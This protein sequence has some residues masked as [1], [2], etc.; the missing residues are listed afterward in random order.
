[1]SSTYRSEYSLPSVPT[2]TGSRRGRSVYGGAGGR[3]VQVS[4]PSSGITAGFDPADSAAR[5]AVADNKKL[6]MKN[7]NDRLASYLAKVRSLETSNA[8]L[9][10]QIREW[11]DKQPPVLRDFSKYDAVIEDLRRNIRD[12][13]QDNASL[14]LQIDNA[15]LAAEDFRIKFENELAVHMSVEGD[16]TGLR[17]VLEDLTMSR[18]DLE[19]QVEGLKEELVYLKKNHAEEIAILTDQI[20]NS[21]VNVEV[22]TKPQE[23]IS[24]VMDDIRTRYECITSKNREETEAWFK[25]KFNDFNK[26]VAS[27][28]EDLQT[29]QC[30][31][32]ELKRTLQGLEIELQAQL[33]LKAALEAQVAETDSRYNVQMNQ[34]QGMVN[35]LENE[36]SQVKADIERQSR[37]Y[38]DLLD[39]KTKLEMEISEYRRL[40]DGEDPKTAVVTTQV[41]AETRPV[42]TQR[43]KVVIEELVDGLVVS[44]HEDME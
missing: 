16:I 32:N 21:S 41:K 1:M 29:T 10:R 13:T 11:Y 43:R 42:V 7:L 44:R 39:I 6:T 24:S 25:V 19:V 17:K 31:V 4:Y 23:S 14:M 12:A 3:N 38:Q 36:L 27:K 8:Q 9:E 15:R 30:E 34:L 28:E 5:A 2:I 26:E 37:D 40:L 35:G 18:S 22:E 20:N 33:R